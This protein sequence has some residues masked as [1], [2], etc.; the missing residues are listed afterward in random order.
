MFVRPNITDYS[1]AILTSNYFMVEIR[2]SY[3][4]IKVKNISLRQNMGRT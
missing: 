1:K 4:N 2:H 3:I